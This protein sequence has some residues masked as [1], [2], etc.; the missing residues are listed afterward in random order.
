MVVARKLIAG[1][2]SAA[3]VAG[4]LNFTFIYGGNLFGY[5]VMYLYVSSAIVFIG[6]P[7]SIIIYVV[8]NWVHSS[9][10]KL[11]VGGFLHLASAAVILAAF[12][13]NLFLAFNFSYLFDPFVYGTILSA[14]LLWVVDV[15]LE[16]FCS[17]K[18]Q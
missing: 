13:S 4:I 18:T 2:V 16:C 10:A 11:V 3:V 7:C 9:I 17:K 15:I 12:N 8:L 14:L 6:V 5:I 1:I